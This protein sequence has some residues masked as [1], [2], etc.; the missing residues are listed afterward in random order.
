MALGIGHKKN[1]DTLVKAVRAGDVALMEC[2]MAVTGETVAVMCAVVEVS[3]GEVE[4][5]P[6]ARMFND[7]PY[8]VVSPP[9]VGGGFYTIKGMKHNLK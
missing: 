6:F 2:E 9:K 4:F 8:K 1:F 3:A 5:F 7:N